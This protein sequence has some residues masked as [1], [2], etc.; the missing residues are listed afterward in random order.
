MC[1]CELDEKVRIEIVDDINPK[2]EY[3]D[4]DEDIKSNAKEKVEEFVKDQKI[5]EDP[6][7][8]RLKRMA[9]EWNN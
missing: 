3:K 8:T 6:R 4:V 2:I 7:Y 9:R 5:Y 1:I